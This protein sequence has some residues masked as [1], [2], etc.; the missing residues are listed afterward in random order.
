MPTYTVK[1]TTIIHDGKT[2]GPGEDIELTEKQAKR[3]S[4]TRKQ[5][6]KNP[7]KEELEVAAAERRDA[8]FKAMQE[9]K[10]SGQGLT[11]DGRPKVDAIE[12]IVGFDVSSGER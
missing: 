7:T 6:S 3:L 9:I 12:K 4:V 1:D 10:D 5:K 2:Y 11:N 8:I